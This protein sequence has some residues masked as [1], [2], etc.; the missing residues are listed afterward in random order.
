MWL[1][2]APPQRRRLI[3]ETIQTSAMDCGPAA[4]KSLLAGFGIRVS[5]GR[6]REACQTDVD[7]TSID[8]LEE[9]ANHLG[10]EAQQIML[11]ADHVLLP[12]AEALPAL[13]V[14]RL[15]NGLTHFVVIW[16]THGRFVQV[17]DPGVGRR[18]LSQERLLQDLYLH[19]QAV[20]MDDW[21]E[22]ASADG[23]CDP[24]RQRLRDLR[25]DAARIEQLLQSALE[26]AHWRALAALDAAARMVASLVR[27]GGLTAGDEAAQMV[28]RF[29]A[30]DAAARIP[31]AFWSVW[32]DSDDAETLWFKGA[33]LVQAL[34]PRRADAAEAPPP[35]ELAA[36]LSATEHSPE[37][38][39]WRLL[40]EDGFFSPLLLLAALFFAATG[41]VFEVFLLKGL[42]DIGRHLG[43]I[44]QR[45]SAFEA[46]FAFFMLM[47]LLELPIA[48]TLIGLG[49]RLE[50]RL[51]MA[52]LKKIPRLGDRYFH[53]RLTSDMAERA[54]DIRILRTLPEVAVK[55]LRHV[56]TLVLTTAGIIWLSPASF[57]L[58]IL[59]GATV[60]GVAFASQPLLRE[61]DLRFRTH[62]AGLARFYLDALLG[63]VP[64]RTHAAARA[65][66]SEH[67][68]LLVNWFRTG[69][70]R[71]RVNVAL[72]ALGMFAN[73]A[74][75]VWILFDYVAQAG[76][77]GGALVLLY[78]ILRL[79]M[80]GNEI[81][82]TA[83]QYPALRNRVLRLL[84]PLDAPEESEMWYAEQTS[85]APA[86]T[87]KSTAGARIEFDAVEVHAGGHTIL[88]DI[89]LR[90]APGEHVAVVGPSGAGK[91]S[92]AGLLLGWHH[93][94]SGTLRVDGRLLQGDT[95]HALRKRTAWVDPAVQIWNRSLHDNLYYG[96][97]E[98]GGRPL[99][100]VVE[101]AGLA[102]IRAHLPADTV[103]GESGGLVSG[104]EGQ[105]VRLGRAMLR[106]GTRLVILDEPFRGLD[107]EQ[108]RLLLE[109]VCEHWREATL[110][111]ISHDVEDTR[112]FGRVL[113]VE[114]GRIREDDAPETLMQAESRYRALMEAEAAVRRGLWESAEWRRLWLEK[115]NLK[116]VAL[117]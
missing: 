10:L 110:L 55:F 20:A 78:W 56:F 9:I 40:K 24:L 107:R 95:L 83:Q 88:Q 103:L 11:P 71:T 15:P 70:A 101:Q 74:L 21:I 47:L 113:V 93:P 117:P 67:E 33:V 111:F 68:S 22:W 16:R 17:M 60:L 108:R 106:P 13:T 64:I 42:L 14:V 12:A 90:I 82:A 75:A 26:N 99:E 46:L 61:Q 41:A 58:A 97:P 43:E 76:E 87:K 34:G 84:E 36:A 69:M 52:F 53:S 5:Y 85:A 25:I 4:L 1:D 45:I 23:F 94:S 89:S 104:G 72:V 29:S 7:G 73:T 65:L 3:P 102:Q 28:M 81:A 54:Y 62:E 63:L 98:G 57:G 115:G 80:V 37:R 35:P 51:R 100:N 44:E 6:L 77:A 32:A 50:I 39:L 79:P 19:E 112:T 27:N 18:W 91:S 109:R 30:A 2:N 59:A 105:R 114:E 96:I 86:S 8:T 48:A 49:R 92:L 116:P 66:R 38:A 31:Q